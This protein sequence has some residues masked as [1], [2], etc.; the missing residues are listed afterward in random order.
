ML[1]WHL[2]HLIKMSTILFSVSFYYLNFQIVRADLQELH[3]L[4][5][6]GA[7]YGYTPFCSDR[8]EMDGFRFV[9]ILNSGFERGSIWVFPIL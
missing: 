7:P 3:D 2:H 4:D 8:K 5:L 9:S 1:W 6:K